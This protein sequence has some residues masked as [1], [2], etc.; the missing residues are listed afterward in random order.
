MTPT[1]CVW[2]DQGLTKSLTTG[3]LVRRRSGAIALAIVVPLVMLVAVAQAMSPA[4]DEPVITDRRVIEDSDYLHAEGSILYYSDEMGSV[5]QGFALTGKADNVSKDDYVVC[6]TAFDC[7]PFTYTGVISEG[8]TCGDYL[9][10]A[11][12]SGLDTIQVTLVISPAGAEYDY[13]YP[14]REDNLDPTS[15]ADPPEHTNESPILVPCTASDPES[16]GYQYPA[17]VAGTYLLYRYDS[18]PWITETFIMTSTGVFSFS[19]PVEN[20][21]YTFQTRAIDNVGN[22]EPMGD[23]N[24]ST[25]YDTLEPDSHAQSPYAVNLDAIPLTLTVDPDLSG[26]DYLRLWYRFEEGDWI[27]TTYTSTQDYWEMDYPTAEGDGIY[28][29]QTIAV[30][31][32]G[33]VE[34][35]PLETGYAETIRDTMSPTATVETPAQVGALSWDVSWLFHDVDPTSGPASYD[36]QY[37]EGDGDW[38][39]WQHTTTLTTAVFGPSV[40]I[41]VQ[42]HLTYTFQAMATDQAGNQSEAW[43]PESSTAVDIQ[44]AY[45]PLVLRNYPWDPY[46]EENDDLE[47]A[48]GPLQNGAQY[49]AY[50]DDRYD[51]YYFELS[52][53]ASVTAKVIN[54][55]PTSTFGDLLLYRDPGAGGTLGDPVAQWGTPGATDMEVTVA[56]GAGKYFVLVHTSDNFSTS[57]L[58][59]LSV[60]W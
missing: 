31:N 30:D 16:V 12:Y 17:G 32:A 37:R 57:Q 36:V 39:L 11:E 6:G 23:D 21:T 8:W 54:F 4:A 58:Y 55:V 43:G 27:S 40:P 28:D 45:L 59:T 56:L 49:R 18:Q 22:L 2:P 41:A 51:F 44:Y 13:F 35:G 34:S 29:F 50:P 47:D 52:S 48:F 38:Q 53:T 10:T 3:A 25:V 60:T 1:G 5:P 15:V 19:P 42:N 26:L 9:V 46:Y 33:N 20:V 14:Y 24:P 7:G